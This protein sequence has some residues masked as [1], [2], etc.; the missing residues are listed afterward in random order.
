MAYLQIQDPQA[1]SV[2]IGIDLGTGGWAVWALL[3]ILGS[4]NAVNLTDGLDGLAT[5]ASAMVFA[6]YTVIAMWQSNQNCQFLSEPTA[7]WSGCYEVR[8][9]LEIAMIAAAY[10]MRSTRLKPAKFA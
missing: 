10:T 6:A 5:G 9:P 8:D 7:A 4:T 2:A 1:P 3:L